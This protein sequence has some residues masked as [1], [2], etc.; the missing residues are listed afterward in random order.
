[1]NP[2]SPPASIPTIFFVF[3]RIGLL[4]FGGG[5]SGWIFR[6]VVL[7]RRWIEEDEFLS[8]LAV[9]QILPGANVANLSIYI[10]HKLKGPLGAAAAIG[11]LLAGPFFA[12]IGFA[13]VYNV[14]RT[15]PFV[16][17]GLDGV[18]AAAIGL[19]LIIALKGAKRATRTPE[20]LIAFVVSFGAVGLLHWS[21]LLVVVIV[22]PLSVLAAWFRKPADA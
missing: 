11:G 5:L 16:E 2:P 14:L 19:V 18:A 10:G 1:M 22:G 17:A 15:L 21:L 13:T 7:I 4:S 6:D 8:G 9:S 12:V 20:A 3:L